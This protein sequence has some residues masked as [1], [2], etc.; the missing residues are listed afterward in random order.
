MIYANFI[1]TL[2]LLFSHLRMFVMYVYNF[3]YKFLSN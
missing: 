1:N 3:K 2:A